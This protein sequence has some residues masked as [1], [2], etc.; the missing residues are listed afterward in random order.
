ME[1]PSAIDLCVCVCVR[2]RARAREEEGYN[3]AHTYLHEIRL[4]KPIRFNAIVPVVWLDIRLPNQVAALLLCRID[5]GSHQ[6]PSSSKRG[7]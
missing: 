4:V 3:A 6:T 5:I 7:V 2:A 1:V